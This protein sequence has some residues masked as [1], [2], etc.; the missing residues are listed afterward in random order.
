MLDAAFREFDR[1]LRLRSDNGSPFASI[2]FGGL[3][4]LSVLVIQAGVEPERIAPGKPQQNGRHERMHLTLLNADA[5]P[6]AKSLREQPD[7]FRAFQ[8]L[9][10]EERP[11]QAL[12]NATPAEHYQISPRRPTPR[13]GTHAGVPRSQP[14][15]AEPPAFASSPCLSDIVSLP[16]SSPRARGFAHQQRVRNS[17][18]C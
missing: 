8:R 4:R 16:L 10:N 18:A 7:R 2:R 12:G 1:P 13:E 3:S 17:S 11:H 9:Y 6:P 14:C 15:R 5:A